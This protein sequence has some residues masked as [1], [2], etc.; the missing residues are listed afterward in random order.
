MTL[1]QITKIKIIQLVII[2]QVE[3]LIILFLIKSKIKKQKKSKS[4]YTE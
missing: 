4:K 2:Y 1:I 3:K